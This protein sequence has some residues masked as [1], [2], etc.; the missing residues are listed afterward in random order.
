MMKIYSEKLC[1]YIICGNI[2]IISGKITQLCWIIIN[3]PSKP[4]KINLWLN[5]YIIYEVNDYKNFSKIKE[6]KEIKYYKHKKI[7]Y[8]EDIIIKHV[9]NKKIINY[10]KKKTEIVTFDYPYKD[11]EFLE[12]Q[13]FESVLLSYKKNKLSVTFE[14][15]DII[16]ALLIIDEK[17]DDL[18]FS[19]GFKNKIEAYLINDDNK[20][21]I[22]P[23]KIWDEIF[24]INKIYSDKIII[25]I[26]LNGIEKTKSSIIYPNHDSQYENFYL[27]NILIKSKFKKNI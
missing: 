10:F 5:S 26:E 2:I 12:T 6:Y 18:I 21:L 22:N 4:L 11:S 23:K 27:N 9:F 3:Q 8:F 1:D 20:H 24:Y 14:I 17:I 15:K 19:W 16:L 25:E 7:N 13:K